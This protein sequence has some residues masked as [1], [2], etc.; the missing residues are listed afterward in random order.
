MWIMHPLHNRFHLQH[1][2]HHIHQFTHQSAKPT[3]EMM[4]MMMMS[5]V[6]RFYS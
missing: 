5:H 3:P 1:R 4:M 2:D 6:R